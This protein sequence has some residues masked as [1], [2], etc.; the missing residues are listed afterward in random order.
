MLDGCSDINPGQRFINTDGV[1]CECYF[2]VY[3]GQTI[4][5]CVVN[6][7][8]S[9]IYVKYDDIK[10]IIPESRLLTKWS[11]GTPYNK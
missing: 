2:N 7:I 5:A 4:V 11:D 1:L 9:T 6:E 10:E 8:N 3:R